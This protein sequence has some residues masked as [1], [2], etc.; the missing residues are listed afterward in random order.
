MRQP[1]IMNVD[2]IILYD[3]DN[4]MHFRHKWVPEIK[5]YCPKTPFILVGTK[6]DLREDQTIK[7]NLGMLFS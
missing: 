3:D 2:T 5:H 7:N 1:N 4:T 6:V